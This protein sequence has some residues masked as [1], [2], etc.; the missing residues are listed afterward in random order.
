MLSALKNFGVTFL[1]SALIFGIIAYFATSFVTG[2]VESIFR[3]EK[4]ELDNII[5]DSENSD[6]EEPDIPGTTPDNTIDGDSFSF[7]MI[8]TDYRPDLYDNYILSS[9]DTEWFSTA[10]PSDSIGVLS[11]GYRTAHVSSITLVILDKDNRNT[12]YSYITPSLRVTTAS[13]Y[14]TLSEV[15]YTYGIDKLCEYVTSLTGIVPDY[16]FILGGS[17]MAAFT[18]VAGTVQ[19]N[20][21]SAVYTD[22]MYYTYSATKQVDG[23]DVNG[24][25]ITYPA[26]NALTLYSGEL[27]M[28]S[29][30]FYTALSVIEHSKADL[31]TKQIVTLSLS[32]AYIDHFAS[33]SKA[34]LGELIT[35]LTATRQTVKTNFTSKDLDAVYDLFSY[36]DEFEKIELTYPCT[37]KSPTETSNGYFKPDTDK[38]VVMFEKYRLTTGK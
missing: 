23:Y 36:A 21:P 30:R 33:M 31:S 34:L 6:G 13:G 26:D 16:S 14:R 12:V 11:G 20:N 10:K 15:Y 18:T 25:R 8:T 7:L 38:A 1:V 5:K 37:Y 29:E 9:D 4:E 32:E 3:S 35:N 2:T 24:E 19:V 17:D 27:D 28:T 22:G